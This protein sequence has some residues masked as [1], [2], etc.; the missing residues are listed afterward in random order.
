LMAL[1]NR[2]PSAAHPAMGVSDEEA[3]DGKAP[4]RK[5]HQETTR[6]IKLYDRRSPPPKARAISPVGLAEAS[7]VASPE[8]E[9][10][11]SPSPTE[12]AA[13]GAKEPEAPPLPRY[14]SQFRHRAW[15]QHH[16]PRAIPATFNF[17][18]PSGLAEDGRLRQIPFAAVAW[19]LCNTDLTGP[20]PAPNAAAAPGQPHGLLFCTGSFVREVELVQCLAELATD[21]MASSEDL[22]L[23]RAALLHFRRKASLQTAWVVAEPSFGLGHLVLY[24]NPLPPPWCLHSPGCRTAAAWRLLARCSPW[25]L[26]HR[27]PWTVRN[28]PGLLFL[29][30]LPALAKL[31]NWIGF[32]APAQMRSYWKHSLRL[33]W[34]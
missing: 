12:H 17:L 5:R 11:R 16:F 30:L 29:G 31:G 1:L 32:H 6:G 3:E 7:R 26:Q 21:P 14:L 2:A 34:T 15:F 4:R 23:M 19:W 9:P 22:A 24:N 8:P 18:R 27:A 33:P 13:D 20:S 25:P 10:A 28:P